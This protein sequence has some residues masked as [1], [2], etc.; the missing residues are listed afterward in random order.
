MTAVYITIDTEYSAGLYK[1]QGSAGRREN[2]D[3]SIRGVTPKGDVGVEYQLD[4][5]DRHGLKAVFFVDPMP[6]L[7]WGVQSIT[8][9]VEP[10]IERGHDVQLHL[11]TEWL[12]YSG[13]NNPLK[14]RIGRNL[15]DFNLDE[16]C[17][18]IQYAIDVLV[19]A[20]APPPVAFR[21][22][23]YGANDNSLRAL[24]AMGI[25]YDSSFP[26]GIA[27]SDCDISLDANQSAPT[28]HCG[29]IEVPI[30]SIRSFNGTRRHA[31]LTALSSNEL[32]A[33]SAHAA[34]NND[35]QFTLV[36]HSFEMMSRDRT[37]MNIIIKRR[38]EN[39]CSR[40]AKM[41]GVKTATYALE[42]PTVTAQNGRSEFLAHNIIRTG[43]RM[44][45]QVVS[46][47]L[48]GAQ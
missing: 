30:G 25:I 20:G 10:I 35:A 43:A 24:A 2:Y 40:L 26:T 36:S 31:Q 38:F 29:V 45:E 23:N 9:I 13:S 21:A 18:L 44:I 11:H 37:R 39:F 22:G 3:R 27:D 15:K 19:A 33:A 28:H 1:L 41:T 42:P 14:D 6:S 16:Q 12:A 46:N 17:V 34:R 32:I 47:Q 48:Y 7:I 4:I 8:D 5:F